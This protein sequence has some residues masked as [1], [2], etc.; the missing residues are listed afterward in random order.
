[1]RIGLAGVAIDVYSHDGYS[2]SHGVTVLVGTGS[3][4]LL[5]GTFFG[6]RN[7]APGGNIKQSL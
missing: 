4:T 5:K 1:L 7:A 3:G 6:P 2:V